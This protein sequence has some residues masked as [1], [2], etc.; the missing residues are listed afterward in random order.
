MKNR[1]LVVNEGTVLKELDRDY[2]LLYDSTT[3]Q[4]L[5]GNGQF[6]E[7]VRKCNG[8]RTIEDLV[9]EIAQEEKQPVNK[10]QPPLERTIKKLSD[11]RI[12]TSIQ[13]PE[14]RDIRDIKKLS[15]FPLNTIYWEVTSACNFNCSHCYNTNSGP[16]NQQQ[17]QLNPYK[18]IDELADSGVIDI[19]LTGGEPFM[20]KNLFKM[21]QYAKSKHMDF[22]IF[23]NGSLI[24]AEKAAILKELN[25]KFLAVSFDSYDENTFEQIRGP[26]YR[27]VLKNLKIMID[28]ELP[29]RMNVVV[30]NG[31][32]SSYSHIEDTIRFFKDIGIKDGNVS[33]DEF[34]PTGKGKDNL[35]FPA[36]PSEIMRNVEKAYE[37]VYSSPFTVIQDKGDLNIDSYC[38]IG[39]SV[40][41]LKNN[42]EVALCPVLSDDE[43]I[44]GSLAESSLLNLWNHSDLFKQFRDHSL[45]STECQRCDYLKQCAGG[46]KAKTKIF[47]NSFNSPDRWMC[48]YFGK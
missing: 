13:N 15:L 9:S 29:I 35:S 26:H 39:V 19:L 10:I 36:E 5:I 43:F 1:I 4:H 18:I 7:I 48:A 44:A 41:Y 45:T 31:L 46:C 23:T 25:P 24:N 2:F 12:V 47:N 3:K 11:D 14:S 28:Y 8:T 20:R 21:I 33:I 30:F 32:N 27:K 38:G 17:N 34:L 37:R 40:C 22:A 6:A 42:G 16:S